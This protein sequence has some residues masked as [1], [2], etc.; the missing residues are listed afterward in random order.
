MDF[1]DLYK[2]NQFNKGL[3]PQEKNEL[4]VYEEEYA[5]LTEELMTPKYRPLSKEKYL[6]QRINELEK[7][8]KYLKAKEKVEKSHDYFYDA[9]DFLRSKKKIS[10]DWEYEVEEFLREK[11]ASDEEV[12]ETIESIRDLLFEY[13]EG[14]IMS[15]NIKD[16]LKTYYRKFKVVIKYV[17]KDG[18]NKVFESEES[19]ANSSQ[20]I[21]FAIVKIKDE[22]KSLIDV[23]VDEIY[24]K[25]I[26]ESVPEEQ[27]E[28]EPVSQTSR[29]FKIKVKY[30]DK[31]G[32]TKILES[33]EFAATS[34]EA[35][36]NALAKIKD[37]ILD[38]QNISSDEIT[39]KAIKKSNH[40]RVQNFFEQAMEILDEGMGTQWKK[41]VEEFLRKKG[42][43]EEE[44]KEVI[45][46][47]YDKIRDYSKTSNLENIKGFNKDSK[48]DKLIDQAD[49]MYDGYNEK[50]VLNFL[51]RNKIKREEAE[52]IIDDMKERYAEGLASR[53]IY[54]LKYFSEDEIK[55]YIL[56]NMNIDSDKAEEIASEKY[57]ENLDYIRDFN[58]DSKFERCVRQ[59]KRKNP[60]VNPWAVCH[61]AL[62]DANK[63]QD[64]EKTI[65]EFLK[66]PVFKIELMYK[67]SGSDELKKETI[68]IP[69]KNKEEAKDYAISYLLNKSSENVE[70]IK[71]T[72]ITKGFFKF[73]TGQTV[74]YNNHYWIV[75]KRYEYNKKPYYDIYNQDDGT[76]VK[77][78]PEY[79]LSEIKI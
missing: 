20:A 59:V 75:V 10:E 55:E 76:K 18:K 25:Q 16:L 40:N 30:L 17:N 72:S 47:I 21:D 74:N 3:T 29:K 1:K 70:E 19:A 35:I 79:K 37:E 77:K 56:D 26:Q 51:L 57:Y 45:E 66:N 69:A 2:S 46:A 31:E 13:G 68:S 64:L 42:A 34:T 38:V 24:N 67:T 62:D 36:N 27:V 11:G 7:I 54:D 43:T 44:I 58:K 9:L 78:V 6:L 14:Q 60:D 22:V 71:E 4:R 39:E 49:D 33:E 12:E 8:I 28:P 32:N 61:A 73:T 63:S 52:D 53:A 23:Q 65:D 5:K 15:K 48:I 50:K 41:Y